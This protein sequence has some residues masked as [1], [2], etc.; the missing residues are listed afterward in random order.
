M[1]CSQ[2]RQRCNA[3]PAL[4]SWACVA[5][6]RSA[7]CCSVSPSLIGLAA[8]IVPPASTRMNASPA[9]PTASH[10]HTHTD[11]QTLGSAQP[12]LSHG[13]DMRQPTAAPGSPVQPCRGQ[14][15][16]PDDTWASL[17]NSTTSP[18]PPTA[19]FVAGASGL[20]CCHCL[21]HHIPLGCLEPAVADA[22]A[23]WHPDRFDH[24]TSRQGRLK[25]TEATAR[26]SRRHINKL[27]AIP[28][29]GTT[30]QVAAT[31]SSGVQAMAGSAATE[32]CAVLC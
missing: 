7:T 15:P 23:V 9:A 26:H 31:A 14:F 27:Q 8:S 32:H 16:A 4:T 17:P 25:H 10:T 30:Q 24:T 6:S 19:L 22:L 5:A 18:S 3:P 21:C 2:L 20:T 11:R 12:T 1:P 28:V 13:T 29:V